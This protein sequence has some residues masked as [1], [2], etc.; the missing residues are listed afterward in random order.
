MKV[1]YRQRFKYPALDEGIVIGDDTDVIKVEE[2]DGIVGII[3]LR[4]EEP[5]KSEENEGV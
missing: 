4:P 1:L 5:E 2:W 3:F